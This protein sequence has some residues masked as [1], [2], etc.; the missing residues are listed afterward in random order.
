LVPVG[1][2]RVTVHD[3]MLCCGIN[4]SIYR[5]TRAPKRRLKFFNKL[6]KDEDEDEDDEVEDDEDDKDEDN[7]DE[8]DEDED[9]DDEDDND[10]DE[11]NPFH[12]DNNKGG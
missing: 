7:D 5:F 4:S 3:E 8:N 12:D 11:S 9:E 2:E 6:K 1:D 10:K